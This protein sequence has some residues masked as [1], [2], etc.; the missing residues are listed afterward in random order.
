MEADIFELV[1]PVKRNTPKT[2][3]L[4]PKGIQK[5]PTKQKS[6]KMEMKW[7]ILESF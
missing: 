7:W 3:K 4:R 1:N 5:K 2:S 6:K